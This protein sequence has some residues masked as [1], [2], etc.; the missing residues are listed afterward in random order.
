MLTFL[1]NLPAGGA[2][3]FLEKTPSKP[4]RPGNLVSTHTRRVPTAV[5]WPRRRSGQEGGY[6]KMSSFGSDCDRRCREDAE[7]LIATAPLTALTR[8]GIPSIS[9]AARMCVRY[10]VGL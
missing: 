8:A 1:P 5:I 6:K 4:F 10:A 2:A 3:G 9:M 7:A